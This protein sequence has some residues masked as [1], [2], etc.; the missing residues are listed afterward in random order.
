MNFL[1]YILLLLIFLGFFSANLQAEM[2]I[3]E[4][5]QVESFSEQSFK[6]QSKETKW[7]GLFYP[8]GNK[9]KSIFGREVDLLKS[10]GYSFLSDGTAI[11]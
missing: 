1:K 8:S 11:K 5:E 3:I 4:N 7:L 10:N 2:I 9:I 6:E